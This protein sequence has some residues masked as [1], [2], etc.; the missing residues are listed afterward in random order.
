MKK[1][2][3]DNRAALSYI[4]S[5]SALQFFK[6]YILSDMSITK[7]ID[8]LMLCKIEDRLYEYENDNINED[9]TNKPNDHPFFE[10]NQ[11]SSEVLAELY[12]I[13]NDGDVDYDNLNKRLGL[14]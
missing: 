2:K 3:N 5:E 7:P 13:W 14:I 8:N 1:E 6:E 10:R 11:K 12:G 9:G 4:L